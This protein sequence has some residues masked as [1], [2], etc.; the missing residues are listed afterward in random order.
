MSKNPNPPTPTARIEKLLAEN[1]RLLDEK[2]RH[3][4]LGETLRI[5]EAKLVEHA[6]LRDEKQ[7][8]QLADV[9]LKRDLCPTKIR[10]YEEAA[11]AVAAE[12][13][14]PCR[15]LASEICRGVDAKQAALAERLTAALKPIIA[16]DILERR[17]ALLLN[18]APAGR[19][20][21]DVQRIASHTLS[22]GFEPLPRARELLAAA[23]DLAA[24]EI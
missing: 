2:V 8:R 4:E 5:E 15:E 20:L 23:A 17:V 7:F 6:D 3:E 16:P 14:P 18:D 24:I 10:Q 22:V 12:L 1:K 11:T 19:D 21:L 9:R 13:I